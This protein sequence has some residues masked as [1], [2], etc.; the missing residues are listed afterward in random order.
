MKKISLYNT[1][2]ESYLQR[3][4][5]YGLRKRKKA[6]FFSFVLGL[7]RFVDE[8]HESLSPFQ[9]FINVIRTHT[10]FTAT[11]LDRFSKYS[12]KYY[13]TNKSCSCPEQ[14]SNTSIF[15]LEE[16]RA[17]KRMWMRIPFHKSGDSNRVWGE[18][19]TVTMF[20]P[21][22]FVKNIRFGQWNNVPN[23]AKCYFS[24]KIEEEVVD[25]Q[26]GEGEGEKGQDRLSIHFSTSSLFRQFSRTWLFVDEQYVDSRRR[27]PSEEWKWKTKKS[28]VPIACKR[29]YWF[30]NR[31]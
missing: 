9:S 27:H 16:K 19:S 7:E 22:V 15:S 4:R 17:L 10:R 11:V 18:D 30:S 1:C 21:L 5:I 13:C 23:L 20:V 14:P 2:R 24:N 28:I 25:S 3:N 31:V 26:R 6:H 8:K 12:F 29:D